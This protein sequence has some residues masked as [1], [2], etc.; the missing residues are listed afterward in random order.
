MERIAIVYPSGKLESVPSLKG[1]IAGLSKAG[2]VIDV[3][4]TT[5]D[6]FAKPE[7]PSEK[8]HFVDV[9]KLPGIY[10]Q[11]FKINVPPRFYWPLIIR[12]RNLKMKYKWVIGVDIKGLIL[13]DQLFKGLGISLAYFSLE[14]LFKDELKKP[15]DITAKNKEIEISQ[16]AKLVIIQDPQRRQLLR[17]EN[18]LPGVEFVCLPNS[19]TG[20]VDNSNPHYLHKKYH[21]PANKKIILSS[22]SLYAWAC[23]PELVYSTRTWPSDWVLVLHS[24]QSMYNDFGREYVEALKLLG[25]ES[26][27]L[28]LD[29]VTEIEYKQALWELP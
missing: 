9:N 14:I 29:P 1:V 2:F 23:I 18:D 8:V 16:R 17:D 11:A 4:I 10:R 28:S 22:G 7:A 15:G 21:L 6:R 20:P 19:P 13:A 27:I 24:R 3:F 25:N 26:I 5:D 12:Q